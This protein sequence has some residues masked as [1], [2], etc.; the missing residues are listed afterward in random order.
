LWDISPDKF[1]RVNRLATFAKKFGK[2]T[3]IYNGVDATFQL[4][5][6]RLTLGGGWNIGNSVQLG[7][8]AGG[9]SAASSN[10][11]FVVDSPQ[12]LYNCDV[13]NPY[14]SRIKIN[15]SYELP[16][17]EIQLAF[18]AQTN[19]GPTYNAL[20]TYTTAQ[21]ATSLGRPLAGN[22][23][24]VTINVVPPFSQFGDR[25]NQLDL[26][27][28]KTVRL[29][30]NRRLQANVDLYNV[31]NASSVVNIIGV[32]GSRFRQ[33]TQILDGRLVRF[34]AQVDF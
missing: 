33:P 4:R 13:R 17:Q 25:I 3:E 5:R 26:R 21:V 24:T 16:W 27:A 15:G 23:R 30:A 28:S 6:N 2:Q 19:P 22:T 20:V 12:Q 11:C 7:T 1:G 9:S 14:Q 31:F 10:T 32:F 29:G 8:T 18:V 34:S